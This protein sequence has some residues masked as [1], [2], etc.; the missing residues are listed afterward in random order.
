MLRPAGFPAYH[1]S[2]RRS[3]DACVYDYAKRR[4]VLLLLRIMPSLAEHRAA[5][6]GRQQCAAA[7]LRAYRTTIASARATSQAAAQRSFEARVAFSL[8][9]HTKATRAAPIICSYR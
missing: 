3:I 7:A 5:F 9:P 1:F 8:E 2:S 4:S 6:I